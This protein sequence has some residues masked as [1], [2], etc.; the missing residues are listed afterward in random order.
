M[1]R[2]SKLPAYSLQITSSTVFSHHGWCHSMCA[3]YL[4]EHQRSTCWSVQ[5]CTFQELITM[6]VSLISPMQFIQICSCLTTGHSMANSIRG[7]S[8]PVPIWQEPKSLSP[9]ANLNTFLL[10]APVQFT[11]CRI[12]C[13]RLQSALCS[14]FLWHS[15]LPC[16]FIFFPT[17]GM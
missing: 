3:H 1:K 17:K 9:Q 5:I 7:Y 4:R 12:I 11:L 2:I 16:C 6:S 13:C 8:I 15:V 14:K 10:T